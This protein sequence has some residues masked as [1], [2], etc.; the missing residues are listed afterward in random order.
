[1]QRAIDDLSSNGTTSLYWINN[2]GLALDSVKLQD[3]KIDHWD[4]M[5][6]TNLQG[7]L[8]VTRAIVPG[9]IERQS[10]M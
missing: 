4:T 1:M 2:A 3:G 10:D 7:L 9:M 5:I 6:N 8:Y